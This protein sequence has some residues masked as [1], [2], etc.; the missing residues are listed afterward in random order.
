[1]GK[2]NK[3]RESSPE[4]LSD[5]SSSLSQSSGSEAA[6][7]NAPSPTE[8]SNPKKRKR[9][10]KS[11]DEIEVD[12]NA[13][14]PPSKKALRKAKKA[15]VTSKS[16]SKSAARTFRDS[17]D[18][19]DSDSGDEEPPKRSEYGIWIGNLSFT[20]TKEHLRQFLLE[21]G[22]IQ[23]QSITRLH[24]PPPDG[25]QHGP[26]K[27]RKHNRGFAYVDFPDEKTLK[28]ALDLSEALLMGRKVLIKNAK[29]YE[30]RP[31]KT[32]AADATSA[33]KPGKEA[34]K[35]LFLG[36]LGFDAT[37]EHLRENFKPCGEMV[38]IHVATFEDT[39]KCKGFAWVEFAELESAVSAM[40]GFV[41][42]PEDRDA[43]EEE[44]LSD[45]VNSDSEDGAKKVKKQKMRKWWVNRIKGRQLRMEY[46]EDKAT[47]Y[48]KRYG[49]QSSKETNGDSGK[50]PFVNKAGRD[51]GKSQD[52]EPK[53]GPIR[54]RKPE[55]GAERL[56][57]GIV[58]SKG[59]KITFD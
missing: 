2:S 49:K 41:R 1:M 4:S 19:S 7:S 16:S 15:K 32:A 31:E 57:G 37:E 59:T 18:S 27:L 9:E 21:Q 25:E 35:T 20:T 6:S 46:A 13:P 56:T 58:A 8:A 38:R 34:S 53:S 24:M 51:F 30:G 52:S 55:T 26:A 14:E 23:S 50:A 17:D 5:S 45:A 44:D 43:D 48:K 29:S 12:I 42:I 10:P 54:T 11:V 36:N 47:R 39:G 3:I 22:S 40:N 28:D 33:V